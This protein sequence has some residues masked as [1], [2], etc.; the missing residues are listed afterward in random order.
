GLLATKFE[1]HSSTKVGRSMVAPATA[2]APVS[3]VVSLSS[4]VTLE[5]TTA[6]TLNG[7]PSSEEK[8]VLRGTTM[9][10]TTGGVAPTVSTQGAALVA[11]ET[12]VDET[13]PPA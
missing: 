10:P 2:N 5:V 8:P 13:V 1:R 4:S 9:S 11:A 3:P 7:I 12:V 6:L